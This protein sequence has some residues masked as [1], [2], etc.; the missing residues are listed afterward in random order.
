M[1]RPRKVL[2]KKRTKVRLPSEVGALKPSKKGGLLINHQRFA[3]NRDVQEES[4]DDE[5]VIPAQQAIS[6]PSDYSEQENERPKRPK[7]ARRGG[8]TKVYFELNVNLQI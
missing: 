6:S 3:A 1:G 5:V 2:K 7:R 4:T 8:V